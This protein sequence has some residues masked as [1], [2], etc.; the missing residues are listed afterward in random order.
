MLNLELI[1]VDR[2]G[3]DLSKNSYSLNETIRVIIR[4]V[5]PFLVLILVALMTLPDD[6]KRLDRFFAKMKTPSLADPEAD[7]KEVALS[8][9]NPGRFDHKKLFPNS[10]WEFNKWDKVDALGFLG[11]CGI[12]LLVIALLKLAVSIGG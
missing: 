10:N 4:T 12:A 11:A 8:Y 5:V 2:L 7:A 6:K 1:A 3:F 9:Q